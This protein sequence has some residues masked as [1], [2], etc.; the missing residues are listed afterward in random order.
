MLQCFRRCETA[1]RIP[2]KHFHNQICGA[3]L[4]RSRLCALR[5]HSHD[6]SVPDVVR[7]VL[8]DEIFRN[9]WVEQMST[10]LV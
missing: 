1:S 5:Q 3:I 7:S 6:G 2:G 10:L 9:K 8:G 4:Q